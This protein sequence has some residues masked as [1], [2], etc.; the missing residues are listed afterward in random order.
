MCGLASAEVAESELVPESI[1]IFNG[2]RS[3]RTFEQKI[4]ELPRIALRVYHVELQQAAAQGCAAQ[5]GSV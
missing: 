5:N 4:Q 1:Y 2:Q 3:V